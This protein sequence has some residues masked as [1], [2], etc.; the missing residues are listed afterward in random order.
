M[1]PGQLCFEITET[2]AISNLARVARFMQ[3]LRAMGCRF[4][5]D[6]FGSGLSSFAY[7]KN[8]PVDYLKIDG[9]FVKG[10]ASDAIDFAMVES[11]NRVGHVMGMRTI[12]EFVENAE[13]LARMREIGVDFVQGYHLHQP[14]SFSALATRRFIADELKVDAIA[15]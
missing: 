13:I 11:I 15:C 9:M 5:L 4:A 8:L 6:D 1:S 3:R 12:A 2:A 14:E 10:A 7:L